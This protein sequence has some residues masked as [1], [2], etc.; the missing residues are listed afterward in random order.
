MLLLVVIVVD[1]FVCVFIRKQNK[2]ISLSLFLYLSRCVGFLYALCS[3]DNKRVDVH[4]AIA[5]TIYSLLAFLLYSFS[6]VCVCVSSEF[7]L[8]CRRFSLSLFFSYSLLLQEGSLSFSLSFFLDFQ[9]Y[10]INKRIMNKK[11]QHQD[12]HHIY[13]I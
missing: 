12:F 13:F 9:L 3:N 11:K 4:H 2:S 7:A 6:L 5:T 1:Y 8:Q 10:K